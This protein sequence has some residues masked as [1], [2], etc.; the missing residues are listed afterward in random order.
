VPPLTGCA[1]KVT[2]LPWQTEFADAVMDK[3]TGTFAATDMAMVFDS[4]GFPTA[5]DEFEV[6]LHDTR[7]PFCGI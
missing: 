6:S 1:V 3:L 5:H 7:S 2:G 4:A